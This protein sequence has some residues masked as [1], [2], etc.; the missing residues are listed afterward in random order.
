MR[1]LFPVLK[2]YLPQVGLALTLVF[3]QAL[4]EL[5]LPTLMAR[6]IDQGV[7]AHDLGAIAAG[8]AAMLGV[9]LAGAVASL[10]AA[11]VT[12]RLSAAFGRDLR[13]AVFR[14][15]MGLSV[16]QF[17]QFGAASLI[18]RTTNDV[19]QVQGFLGM[20]LRMLAAAPLMAIGG[21]VMA[22]ALDAGLAVVL[23]VA[24]PLLVA[25]IVLV[26]LRGVVLFQ[27]VQ[28]R[29]DRLNLVLR[30]SLGGVRVIRAFDRQDFDAQRFQAANLDLADVSLKTQKLMALVMP[31]MMLI[32]SLTSVALVWFGGLRIQAGDLTVGGLMAFL[33]YAAMILFS[34]MM[35]SMLFVMGPRAAV[36]AGRIS[37]VLGEPLPPEPPVAPPTSFGDGG[38]GVEFHRVSFRYPQAE[39]AAL[40]EVSFVADPGSVTAVIGGT[41]AGK[42]TIVQLV[43]GFHRPT[44]GT[45]LIGG[46]DTSSWSPTEWRKAIGWV[47]Q[48]ARL[49]SGTVADNLRFG[50]PEAT[51]ADLQKALATAQAESFVAEAGGLATTV[52]RGGANWSGGQR[53][54]LA[55]ARALARKPRLLLLDDSFSA[56][57]FRT[58]AA[59]RG[60]LAREAAGTT[61]LVVAQR[62]ATVRHADRIVVLDEG[63]VAGVG[64]HDELLRTCS[65]YEE[66]VASQETTEE[67]V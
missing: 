39:E 45:L 65:V 56:L 53:Q 54:R 22:L 7:L 13:S 4:T 24:I 42:T 38:L 5:G 64:T 67:A 29:I 27:A 1:P 11:A 6:I 41:G 61:V 58:D 57:D 52:D 19:T 36:S 66:I 35:L 47:P 28:K 26:A 49:F 44:S 15:T 25:A 63:R 2:P 55:I 14:K 60:A 16:T 37:A 18:T 3:V 50:A 40:E 8:G 12:A 17:D 30:E 34:L 10:V 48:K 62:V 43:E 9:A 31:G 21:I 59:L 51:E 32:M 46:R 23:L 20:G 33:Q